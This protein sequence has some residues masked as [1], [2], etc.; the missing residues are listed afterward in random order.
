MGK[1]KFIILT[2]RG[3]KN[4][5]MQGYCP[6][7]SD[8]FLSVVF[9]VETLSIIWG[10]KFIRKM[11]WPKWSFSAKIVFCKIDP[12]F[13]SNSEKVWD[14]KELK[15]RFDFCPKVKKLCRTS[16]YFALSFFLGGGQLLSSEP[17]GYPPP[18][19]RTLKNVSLFIQNTTLCI[20]W[21]D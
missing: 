16:P 10:G 13:V 17:P 1:F 12:F 8:N 20:P 4:H 21:P 11:F 9:W 18:P 6:Q 3:L 14:E 19:N 2:L 5:E 15:P 7:C